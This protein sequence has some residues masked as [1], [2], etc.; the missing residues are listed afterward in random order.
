MKELVKL[1]KIGF[2]KRIE[3][4]ADLIL[5]LTDARTLNPCLFKLEELLGKAC[6]AV[7]IRIDK[8]ARIDDELRMLDEIAHDTAR[9]LLHLIELVAECRVFQ[10]LSHGFDAG[11]VRR[12]LVKDLFGKRRLLAFKQLPDIRLLSRRFFFL[13]S[14]MN[15]A[16]KRRSAADDEKNS[17]RGKM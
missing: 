3:R 16:G 11:E 7:L 13:L 6:R 1:R 9:N 14:V 8:A 17:R 12:R 10:F 15:S 5:G 2:I 4:R